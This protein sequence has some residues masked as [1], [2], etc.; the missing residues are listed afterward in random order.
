MSTATQT[1]A[2][3]TAAEQD[4]LAAATRAAHAAEVARRKADAARERADDER[5]RAYQTYLDKLTSEYPAA[6]EQA[7]T[8]AGEARAALEGAVR[9]DDGV[10]R[11]YFD[12]VSASVQTWAIDSELAQIRDHHGL[13]VRATDPPA[14]RFDVDVAMIV[15][16]I[17]AE[18]QDTAV[19]RITA[20]RV[21]FVNGKDSR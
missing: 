6:R 5:A 8:A 10:F 21:N 13:P 16:G 11:A 7:L 12:W 18:L 19:Q 2:D 1:L 9:G 3:I 20:R 14:F 4:A 15:D 17:A